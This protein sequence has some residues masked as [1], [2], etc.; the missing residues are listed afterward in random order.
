MEFRAFLKN[1]KRCRHLL[2]H[3]YGRLVAVMVTISVWMST[4][5][6]ESHWEGTYIFVLSLSVR[7]ASTVGLRCKTWELWLIDSKNLQFSIVRLEPVS[8]KIS[9]LNTEEGSFL[10]D[11]TM[12]K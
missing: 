5:F 6:V 3:S 4:N 12:V 8:L 1:R 11:L 10:K 7:V 2:G 9:V